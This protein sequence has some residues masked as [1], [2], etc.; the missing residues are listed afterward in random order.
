MALFILTPHTLL[1]SAVFTSNLTLHLALSNVSLIIV[2]A[3]HKAVCAFSL[4]LQ[5]DDYRA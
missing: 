3:G 2:I 4:S 5:S 1:E